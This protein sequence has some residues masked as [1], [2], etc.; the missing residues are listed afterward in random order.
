[1]Q[2]RDFYV[3]KGFYSPC[4]STFHC[5]YS[6]LLARNNFSTL[7]IELTKSSGLLRSV[8]KKIRSY[9]IKPGKFVKRLIKGDDEKVAI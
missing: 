6:T 9:N 2:I 3:G 1:M 5:L 8:G 7:E 4:L